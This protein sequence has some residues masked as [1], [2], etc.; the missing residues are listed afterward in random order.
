[1]IDIY[2]ERVDITRGQKTEEEEEKKKELV[3]E[4]DQAAAERMVH[5]TDMGP[6]LGAGIPKSPSFHQGLAFAA[7]TAPDGYGH[8]GKYYASAAAL[9]YQPL[10]PLLVGKF[11][12]LLPPLG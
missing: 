9:Q 5:V 4:D 11:P 10:Q 12:P 2:N 6:P 8:F 7:D 1:M 3:D